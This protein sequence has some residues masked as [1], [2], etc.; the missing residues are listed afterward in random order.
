MDDSQSYYETL[1]RWQDLKATISKLQGEERAL[2]EGLFD[3]AFPEPKEGTNTM[4]M[5]DGRKLKGVFKINRSV[6]EEA[7]GALKL[8]PTQMNAN[9]RTT[10]S[11]KITAYKELDVKTRKIIDSV[12]VSR[13]GLPTLDVKEAKP[14]AA[15]VKP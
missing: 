12:L 14:A 10:H 8:T 4:E 9:F 6:N 1:Q 13:P 15:E 3:G 5:P 2:R 7:L 11:L